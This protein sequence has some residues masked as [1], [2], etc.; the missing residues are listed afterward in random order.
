M[1]ALV[2]AAFL[3]AVYF[4]YDRFSRI[5]FKRYRRYQGKFKKM[6]TD[7]IEKWGEI[8][9][10][11]ESKISQ[12]RHI[13]FFTRAKLIFKVLLGI[14]GVLVISC[15]T[16]TLVMGRVL[17][18][19]LL[20][21][22][23]LN[24]EVEFFDNLWVALEEIWFPLTY[25][26][27]PI[28]WLYEKL[29]SID[30]NFD[31]INITCEGS[32]APIQLLID[33]SIVGFFVVTISSRLFEYHIVWF[34]S[35]NSR[36]ALDM[37]I[38]FLSG[39]QS[40][41]KKK[42]IA[43]LIGSI[44]FT[45]IAFLNP[46]HRLFQFAMTFVY[47]IP[48]TRDHGI[49][50]ESTSSC[51]RVQGYENLDSFYAK[52]ASVLG[53]V[54]LIVAFYAIAKIFIPYG[55]EMIRLSE[56]KVIM[57]TQHPSSKSSILFRWYKHFISYF[58]IDLY[59]EHL[60]NWWLSKLG[61]ILEIGKVDDHFSNEVEFSEWEK[62]K[63]RTVYSFYPELMRTVQE[64]I[65]KNFQGNVHTI[66]SILSFF[67]VG[68][69][70]TEVGRR[71]WWN[72][73]M[74]YLIFFQVCLGVWTE[75]SYK[76]LGLDSD[77][78]LEG[79]EDY[80]RPQLFSLQLTAIAASRAIILQITRILTPLSVYAMATSG[81]PILVFS[82][83]MGNKLPK[84]IYS[85]N[86]CKDLARKRNLPENKYQMFA[87]LIEDSRL[88]QYFVQLTQFIFSIGFATAINTSI[89][90]LIAVVIFIPYY[91]IIYIFKY[92]AIVNDE[93]ESYTIA[94]NEIDIK[95]NIFSN[96]SNSNEEGVIKMHTKKEKS[97]LQTFKDYFYF[98]KSTHPTMA[99][100]N[101]PLLK[102]EVNPE[103]VDR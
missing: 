63:N 20:I 24:F 9:P 54:A 27:Y 29:A 74:K 41:I 79:A 76:A 92:M 66:V 31:A 18:G 14:F 50:H 40:K 73:F 71:V 85:I 47:I 75:S 81:S 17:F 56:N 30:I 26:F 84:L 90:I 45:S 52:M 93:F 102:V 101:K 89:W 1:F 39:K 99:S 28:I 88:I 94:D 97:L 87:I 67:V 103:V 43:V 22:R 91:F 10:S 57:T 21:V 32:K 6:C 55:P 3:I 44:F 65:D 15:L 69:V 49:T 64:E 72:V 46:L 95:S 100:L 60:Y 25:V 96:T 86:D 77:M 12:K 2:I 70:F 23:A 8:S 68:H 98:S 48:F 80:E 4:I 61:R 59:I 34:L 38:E 51:D 58:A 42:R 78:I 37:V 36:I 83:S 5:G 19:S 13:Y 7:I 62:E 11:I 35:T 82:V 53:I 33:V 16:F